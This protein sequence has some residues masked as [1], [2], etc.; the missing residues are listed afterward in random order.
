MPLIEARR[1][2]G[3][4]ISLI[5]QIIALAPESAINMAFGELNFPMPSTMRDY[6]CKLLRASNPCYT[7][8]AGFAELRESIASYYG[9]GVDKNQIC[10]CNG[11][12]EALFIS[13]YGLCNPSDKIAIPDPEYP[14]YPA[15]ASLMEAETVRLGFEADLRTINWECWEQILAMDLKF[16]VFSNPQNP[17]GYVYD[18]QDLIQLSA[19]CNHYGITVIADEIYRDLCFGEAIP[20]LTDYFEQLVIV[21]GLSKSHLMS[22]WRLGWIYAPKEIAATTIKAKQYISTCSNWLSQ[23]LA[24]YALGSEGQ[25]VLEEVR[26]NL[27]NCRV[28]AKNRLLETISPER[29]FYPTATPYM[30]IEV[31][32]DDMEKAQ[33]LAAAG[34]ITVPGR[35]F[36]KVS[37]GLIRI[38][39]ALPHHELVRACDILCEKL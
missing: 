29:L 33:S 9:P 39:C 1:F 37:Q 30:M 32:A 18:D 5:R 4:D 17:S 2:E 22:G 19:I 31:L 21:G 10:V 7:P 34:L 20:R 25:N 36:G 14:A 3:L 28:Y 38:N 24:L 16:L 11:V 8:N 13:L 23:K 12:E 35:A 26:Q 27:H 15:L 6:A